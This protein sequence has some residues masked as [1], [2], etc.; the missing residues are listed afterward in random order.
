MLL[1]TA[2]KSN[3]RAL[4]CYFVVNKF[5]TLELNGLLCSLRI[6]SHE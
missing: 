6:M 1:V 5:Q 3:L 2:K 4:M